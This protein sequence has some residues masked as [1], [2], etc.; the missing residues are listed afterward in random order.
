M[1]VCVCA[2]R[3]FKFEEIWNY[4][5]LERISQNSS[6]LFDQMKNKKGIS[7]DFPRG[8][9][10]VPRRWMHWSD[11]VQL[12]A[13]RDCVCVPGTGQTASEESMARMSNYGHQH[14]AATAAV[15]V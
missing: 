7:G 6:V 15:V 2:Q 5:S 12:C 10:K 8:F 4:E 3:L 9:P 1:C 14:P 11:S 13:E